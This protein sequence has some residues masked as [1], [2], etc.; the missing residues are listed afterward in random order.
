VPFWVALALLLV[1]IGLLSTPVVIGLGTAFLLVVL[2]VWMAQHWE[3]PELPAVPGQRMSFIGAGM[4]AFI[5][6]ETVFFASLI[7]ADIHLRIH[8]PVNAVGAG[9]ATAFPAVNTG[10]L[11]ASGVAA[12]YAQVAYRKRRPQSFYFLLGLTIVLGAAFLGGQAWEYTHLGFG[13]T[14]SLTASGFFTLTGFHGLHV[15]CGIATLVFLMFRVRR[16]WRLWPGAPSPGTAGMVDAGTYY[17]HFV[18]AVWVV[19][20]VVV[21]LL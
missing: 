19:V 6:S 1:A 18:D 16:E 10:V 9:L 15:A 4:L 21:Y 17:W 11:I 12:H 8:A 20:F 13:L 2:A 14:A 5:G 3:Q 7:A